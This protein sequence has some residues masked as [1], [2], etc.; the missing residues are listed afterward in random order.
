MLAIFTVLPDFVVPC[1]FALM[2][3]IIA[4]LL[5]QIAKY[6]LQKQQD[7]VWPDPV[8]GEDSISRELNLDKQK[9]TMNEIN[10]Y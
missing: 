4:L 5:I 2:D 8:F 6:Q 3:Y 9:S 10:Y 7:E 1:L